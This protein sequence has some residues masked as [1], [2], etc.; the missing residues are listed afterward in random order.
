MIIKYGTYM[1]TNKWRNKIE[2]ALRLMWDNEKHLR[3]PDITINRCP[4][5]GGHSQRYCECS[6]LEFKKFIKIEDIEAFIETKFG[7]S[8]VTFI[9]G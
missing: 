8:L 1:I 9:Y 2:Q 6:Y 5:C 3:M 4:D 7:I